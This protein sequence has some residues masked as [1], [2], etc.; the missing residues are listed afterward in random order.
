MK[1]LT[2]DL[3]NKPSSLD[4]TNQVTFDVR[5]FNG[6]NMDFD[7]V[8]KNGLKLQR[9]LVWTDLQKEQFIISILKGISIPNLYIYRFEDKEGN[10]TYKVIDGKQR[11]TTLLDFYHGKFSINV[12]GENYFYEDLHKWL[13]SRIYT[14]PLQTVVFY[15][16]YDDEISDK[17]LVDIFN[18]VNF[19]GTPQ[20]ESHIQNLYK[21]LRV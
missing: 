14:K 1:E 19:S 4:K 18:Y 13:K 16:Y 20:D 15:G 21:S 9:D 6:R 3:L 11:I 17:E 7:V 2:E 10:Q 5:M 8:L 12:L